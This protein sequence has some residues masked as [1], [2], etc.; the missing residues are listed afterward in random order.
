[1]YV[2]MF[3]APEHV[4]MFEIAKHVCMLKTSER[5]CLRVGPNHYEKRSVILR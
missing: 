5:V 1:M 2:C 4:C 3:E